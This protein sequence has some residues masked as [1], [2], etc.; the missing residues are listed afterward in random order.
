V[1]VKTE[2]KASFASEAALV[3]AYVAIV[4]ERN[5]RLRKEGRNAETAGCDLLL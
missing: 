5:D 3:A 2:R 4:E 1:G